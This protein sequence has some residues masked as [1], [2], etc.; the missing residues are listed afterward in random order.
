[1]SFCLKVAWPGLFFLLIVNIKSEPDSS[2]VFVVVSSG[3]GGQ[4]GEGQE[5]PMSICLGLF[6][7][8]PQTCLALGHITTSGTRL[9][10]GVI[11]TVFLRLV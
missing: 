5:F 1:M 9:T 2:L 7:P 8:S 3:Q 10:L 11:H 4:Q 6:F